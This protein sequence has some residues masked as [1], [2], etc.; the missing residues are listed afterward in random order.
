MENERVALLH[1]CE[2]FPISQPAKKILSREKQKIIHAHRRECSGGRRG[3]QIIRRYR[4]RIFKYTKI[5]VFLNSDVMSAKRETPGIGY[6][7]RLYPTIVLSP[8]TNRSVKSAEHPQ[9]TPRALDWCT[10][11]PSPRSLHP[12]P[13]CRNRSIS[14]NSPDV[15]P[16]LPKAVLVMLASATNIHDPES[17]AKRPIYFAQRRE[18]LAAQPWCY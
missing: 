10:S 14:L 7:Y 13:R 9:A 5:E 4:R 8:L 16:R 15:V 1:V 3:V 12:P 2:P 18:L 11:L 6:N 17:F